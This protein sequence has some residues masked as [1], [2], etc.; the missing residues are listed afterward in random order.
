MK[1]ETIALILLIIAIVFLAY[2]TTYY[3]IVGIYPFYNLRLLGTSYLFYT[4]NKN[5]DFWAAS[6]ETVTAILWDYRGLD[7]VFETSVFF[8]AII[9][10]VALFRLSPSLEKEF[11]KLG[12]KMGDLGLSLIVKLVTKLILVMIIAISASIALH[13]QLTPGGGF[14]GGSALA[15]APILLIVGLSVWFTERIGFRK[16]VALA[17]R[18][19]GLVSITL[20]ALIPLI[21]TTIMG[22]NSYI[23]QNQPKPGAP[24]SYPV[25]VADVYGGSLLLYNVAEYLA[26]A[27]GFLVT[28][29][30]LATPELI[31]FK[32]LKEERGEG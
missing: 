32:A 10:A 13:G 14:Q 19:I 9:S 1:K 31:Y 26:V 7:T 20:L 4:L 16:N 28:F 24:F 29:I 2:L 30:L 25:K 15:V 18:T 27:N 17:L 12:E 3:E 6:P 22:I 8:L 23:M 11:K 5:S 21:S